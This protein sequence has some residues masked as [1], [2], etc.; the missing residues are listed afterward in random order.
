MAPSKALLR[1]PMPCPLHPLPSL[2]RQPF[3]PSATRLPTPRAATAFSPCHAPCTSSILNSET[4]ACTGPRSL[5]SPCLSRGPLT[6]ARGPS[7]SQLPPSLPPVSIPA[8]LPSWTRSS[9]YFPGSSFLSAVHRGACGLL[10]Y[11]SFPS[12]LALR[13][14]A[15]LHDTY[16]SHTSRWPLCLQTS[17]SLTPGQK[18]LKFRSSDEQSHP[19]TSSV[20]KRLPTPYPDPT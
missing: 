3:P 7:P 17:F 5:T 16:G 1:F 2:W 14:P 9:A 13:W 6:S 12:A 19:A 4:V 20:P 15:L 8:P 18:K 11:S 10:G